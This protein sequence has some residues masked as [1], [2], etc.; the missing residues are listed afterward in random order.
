MELLKQPQMATYTF[1]EQALQLYLLRENFLDALPI[2][3]VSS[4]A[5][6]FVSYVKSV[7]STVF[8]RI[9][10]TAQMDSDT[11]GQ[12]REIAQEFIGVFAPKE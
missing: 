6:Q 5:L 2:K 7:Y 1:V 3:E 8:E 11:I 9:E 12:L 10:K 4:C